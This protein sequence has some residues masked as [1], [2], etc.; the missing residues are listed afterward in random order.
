MDGHG[1]SSSPPAGPWR[2][3]GTPR[4]EDGPERTVAESSGAVGRRVWAVAEGYLPSGSYDAQPSRALES[5]ETV[6]LLNA[7]DRDAE[8]ALMLYFA[9]REPVGPYRFTVAARRTLHVRFNDLEQPAPVPRDTDF[10]SVLRSS[11]PI[12]VQ[13][14]RLDSRQPPH[15]LLSTVAWSE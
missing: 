1:L 10:A 3:H 15:A 11:E 4:R 6:C 12:V 5:H 13:H 7:G 14:S 2:S 9:D 8:V